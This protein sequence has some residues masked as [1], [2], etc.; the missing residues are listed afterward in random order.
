MANL[1]SMA[2]VNSVHTLHQS[3]HSN[4]E[5]ARLLGIDRAAVGKYAQEFQNQPNAPT[6][7]RPHEAE[8]PHRSGPASSCLA[9]CEIILAKLDAGLS[10]NPTA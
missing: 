7:E 8:A 10:A 5:I 9:F 2:K 1:L 4:R 3:G 6:G